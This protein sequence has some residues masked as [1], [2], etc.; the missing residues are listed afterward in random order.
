[1]PA[2]IAPAPQTLYGFAGT[3]VVANFRVTRPNNATPPVQVPVDLTGATIWMTVKVRQTDPDSAAVAQLTI[4]NGIVVTGSPTDGTFTG[5]MD[6]TASANLE[7]PIDLY[8]DVKVKESSGVSSIPIYG[9][10]KMLPPTT[11]AS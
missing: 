11:D 3:T 6:D 2:P 9:L 7:A 1:L 5:M 8:Y 4:G 10:L